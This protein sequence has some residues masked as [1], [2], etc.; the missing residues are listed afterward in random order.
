MG[1]NLEL[2]QT[3]W[4]LGH[5][6]PPKVMQRY[7]IYMLQLPPLQNFTPFRPMANRFRV[8]GHFTQVHW[9][10][11]NW[12]WTLKGQRYPIYML[13]YPWL[14]NFTPFSSSK[15]SRFWVTGH[16]EASAPND[17]KITLNTERSKVPMFMLQLPPSPKFHSVSLYGQLFSSYRPFW[18]QND[19]KN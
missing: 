13:N 2:F 11:P 14:P 9:M 12:P 6:Q 15:A 3:G 7:P 19:F 10:T 4:A 18:P 16:L 1:L 5:I 8:T 17:P